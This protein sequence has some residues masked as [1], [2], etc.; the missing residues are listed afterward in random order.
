MVHIHDYIQFKVDEG[1]LT[2]DIA[3][4]LGITPAMVG[5]YRLK[6]GFKPSLPVAKR[7]YELTNVTLHPFAEESIKWEIEND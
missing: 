5:Q 6:R 7:V 1:Q 4:E 3:I 2:K